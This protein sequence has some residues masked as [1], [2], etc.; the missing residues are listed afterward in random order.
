MPRSA[1]LV[2]G[3]RY[4]PFYTRPWISNA[5]FNSKQDPNITG[6]QA[7]SMDSAID[8][9]NDSIELTVRQ[10]R[11]GTYGQK[12]DWHL[13]D[14]AGIL[15]R[16]ANRRYGADANARPAWWTPY[17]L[18]A[19]LQALN[20]LPDSQFLTGDGEGGRA[21]GG[22]FSLDG[23]H[24]TT[25]AYGII[26]QEMINIMAQAGVVFRLADGTP[27]TG[28]V[29][30]DFARLLQRDTLIN[31]PPQNLTEGLDTLGWADETV[32]WVKR[33]LSFRV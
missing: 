27:R 33:A 26:A 3:S 1:M 17:P 19:A 9:Y 7:R 29:N 20:P 11:D 16:L 12:L 13:L 28:P 10:G 23:V 8:L 32:D 21:T 31:K 15:D 18:P 6:A 14:V 22:L 5:D 4:F 30:V 2:P 24:P 25:V